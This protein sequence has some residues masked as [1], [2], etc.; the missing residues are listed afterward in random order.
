ML[1][2]IVGAILIAKF[3]IN[4]KEI[5]EFLGFEGKEELDREGYG[6]ED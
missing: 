2:C 4:Y 6:Y 3:V 1:C 5:K